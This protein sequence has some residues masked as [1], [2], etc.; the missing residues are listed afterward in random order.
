MLIPLVKNL[1]TLLQ[2]RGHPFEFHEWHEGHSWGNWRAHVDNVLKLFFGRPTRTRFGSRENLPTRV[3]VTNYPNP[4]NTQTTFVL[5][6][7]SEGQ[8]KLEVYDLQGKL[9]DRVA[10]AY[11]PTGEYHF[12]WQLP[13]VSSGLYFYRLKFQQQ[14]YSG[15]L[16]F[17]KKKGKRLPRPIY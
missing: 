14:D 17:F 7:P 4:F 6:L 1:K 10:D 11:L 15:K 16:L 8:V 9:T 5:N 2:E 3:N 12:L 13:L